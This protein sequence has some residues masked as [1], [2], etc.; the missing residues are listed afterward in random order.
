MHTT[1]L[2]LRK[3]LVIFDTKAYRARPLPI[4]DATI[5]WF[6]EGLLASTVGVL[7]SIK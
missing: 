7:F 4:H 6:L 5:V 2:S 1:E 3:R